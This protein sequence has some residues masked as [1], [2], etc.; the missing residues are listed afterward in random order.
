MNNRFEVARL[1]LRMAEQAARVST[2]AL[3]K[4]EAHEAECGR[5]WAVL[6]RLFYG[7]LVV[8]ISI[9]GTVLYDTLWRTGNLPPT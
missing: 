2:T 9:L 7:A 1:A 4:I 6:V 3:T 8:L 5:R